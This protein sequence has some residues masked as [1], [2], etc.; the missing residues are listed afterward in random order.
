[1]DKAL[2]RTLGFDVDKNQEYDSHSFKSLSKKIN[3]KYE[4]D[5]SDDYEL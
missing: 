5:K 1:M 3:K 4:K 2:K